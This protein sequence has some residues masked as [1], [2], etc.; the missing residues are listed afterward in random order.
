ME[1]D[2]YNPVIVIGA[3]RSGTNMLRDIL[4]TLPGFGTWDCDEINPIWRYGN[5]NTPS[6]VF[7]AEM[8]RPEVARYIRGA[9]AK[10]ALKQG[11]TNVVEKSCANSLRIPFVDAIFPKARY[12]FIVRDGRDTVVSAEER[13][14]A[15]F[16]L[17]YAAKKLRYVPWSDFPIYAARFGFNRIRQLLSKENRLSFW[18]VQLNVMDELLQQYDL[19]EICALQ[20]KMCVEKS[21]ADLNALAP[22]RT[23]QVKYED[24][25]REPAK[26]LG[27]I[28]PFL[29]VDLDSVNCELLASGVR[30]TSV[31]RY[32]D[33]L[34]PKTLEKVELLMGD[35]L[36]DFAY[37]I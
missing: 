12:L 17:V 10:I 8:A 36:R 6:D 25:V 29:G 14:K 16:D 30:A 19:Q 26:E 18:G 37:V 22:K 3:A 27:R 21:A 5:L 1:K 11:V 7:S 35:T 28:L 33:Q 24:F 20:W 2:S 9:F 15:S 32:R 34:A 13:W 4:T 23:L 31:G